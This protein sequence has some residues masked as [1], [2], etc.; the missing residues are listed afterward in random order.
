MRT[1]LI[2]ILFTLSMPNSVKSQAK[3]YPYPLKPGEIFRASTTDDTLYWVMK[4][5]Q[6]D[7]AIRNSIAY[8]QSKDLFENL[9]VK[10]NQLEEIVRV[11]AETIKDL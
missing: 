10:A 7:N 9:K 11:N 3:E 1:L 5:L 4:S 2:F 6:F 8:E